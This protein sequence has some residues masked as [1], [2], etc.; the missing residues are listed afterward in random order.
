MSTEA[1]VWV[2]GSYSHD[3]E[4]V[5]RTRFARSRHASPPHFDT[6][7]IRRVL[8]A[9][10]PQELLVTKKSKAQ[11]C[12]ARVYGKKDE[13]AGQN[14]QPL[15]VAHGGYISKLPDSNETFECIPSFHVQKNTFV[16]RNIL[17]RDFHP[18]SGP[19][20]RSAPT[21]WSPRPCIGVWRMTNDLRLS[22]Q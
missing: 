21:A 16:G 6:K 3:M 5:P 17:L 8:T 22:V 7:E 10:S 12:R 20:T 9:P 2:S 1:K 4:A 14:A 18:M 15:A 19:H 11:N 13:T